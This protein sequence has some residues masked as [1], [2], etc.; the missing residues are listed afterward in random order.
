[1]QD[2][3]SNLKYSAVGS[4][5]GA[6]YAIATQVG[7]PV[8]VA[9]MALLGALVAA[10][11]ADREQWSIGAVWHVLLTLAVSLALGLSC[12]KFFGMLIVGPILKMS[13]TENV[14][15]NSADPIAALVISMYG[16]K[17]FLPIVKKLLVDRLS[18]KQTSEN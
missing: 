14:P 1:M 6:L 4:V 16:Y 3:T 12:A 10:S 5:F 7:V 8:S 11:N 17:E 13:G 2:S 18:G 15:A 9:L